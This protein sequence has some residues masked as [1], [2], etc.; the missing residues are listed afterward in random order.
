MTTIPG[1]EVEIYHPV[2]EAGHLS[3]LDARILEILSKNPH[4]SMEEL[5]AELNVPG[6]TPARAGQRAREILKSH[7]WLSIVQIKGLLLHDFVELRDEVWRRIN[8]TEEKITKHGDLVEVDSS[9][10]WA[11]VMVRL[12]RE[13]RQTLDSMQQDYDDSD[14]KLRRAHAEYVIQAISVMFDRYQQ[15]LRED[16]YA[17]PTDRARELFE[18]VLPIGL[19]S[20]NENTQAA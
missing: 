19:Q 9:P 15:L 18:Q 11:N 16:G 20:L 17:I 7:D 2:G 1:M 13:W 3:G 14:T 5:A 10:A 4:Q 8:G 12:L 6:M